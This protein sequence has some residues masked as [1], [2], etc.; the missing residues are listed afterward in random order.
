MEYD[1]IKFKDNDFEMDVNVSPNDDNI[2]LTQSQIAKLFE[3]ERSKITR[4]IKSIKSIVKLNTLLFTIKS[5][6]LFNGTSF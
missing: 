2:W 4:Y 6:K 1:T 5:Q 3:E